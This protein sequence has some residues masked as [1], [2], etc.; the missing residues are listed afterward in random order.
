M[1]AKVAEETMIEKWYNIKTSVGR[2]SR[3]SMSTQPLT[4]ML[5]ITLNKLL[6]THFP[7][8]LMGVT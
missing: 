1:D 7:L 4:I 6:P 3:N 5:S 8:K 2:T